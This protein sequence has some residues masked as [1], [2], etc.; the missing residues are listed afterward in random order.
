MLDIVDRLIEEDLVGLL[1]VLGD[2]VVVFVALEAASGNHERAR[3]YRG[4]KTKLDLKHHPSIPISPC[5]AGQPACPSLI[6]TPL[7]SRD[8]QSRASAALLPRHPRCERS[9]TL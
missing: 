6:T 3:N 1:R 8:R 2:R 5:G 4:G 9:P 7:R